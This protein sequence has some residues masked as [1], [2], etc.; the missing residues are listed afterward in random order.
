[1]SDDPDDLAR[2]LLRAQS[3]QSEAGISAFGMLAGSLYQSLAE[4]CP[5]PLAA[6]LTRDWF[7]LQLS[8]ILWP[9]QLPGAMFWDTQEDGEE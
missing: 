8:R 1:M 6:T 5:Q 4:K 3:D 9:D 7:Y 2:R